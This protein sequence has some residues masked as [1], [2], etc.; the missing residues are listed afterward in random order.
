LI[1][2]ERTGNVRAVSTAT[3]QG[4]RVTVTSQYL[5]DRSTPTN[6]EYVFSYTVRIANEGTETA[7]LKSR[8]WIITDGE[9]NVQEVKGDGVVGAQPTLKPGQSFEYTSGCALRT[10]R[11]TMHGTYQMV[12]EDGERFDAVIAPFALAL[13]HSLN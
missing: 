2:A 12:R 6:H 13:P 11:G 1:G 10:P 7:Q 9:G 3:T 4:I 8:H 5:P